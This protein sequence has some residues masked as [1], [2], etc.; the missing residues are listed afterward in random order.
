MS[1]IF[2]ANGSLYFRECTRN[3]ARL[4]SLIT[5]EGRRIQFRIAIG[6]QSAF[7]PYAV[8]Y[9]CLVCVYVWLSIPWVTLLG[10]QH[11]RHVDISNLLDILRIS[12][13]QDKAD[14]VHSQF[15]I[16][17]HRACML[18]YFLVRCNCT[19]IEFD[20]FCHRPSVEQLK[21]KLEWANRTIWMKELEFYFRNR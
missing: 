3:Q 13:S 12:D 8:C 17:K 19:L 15:N 7:G 9:G 14:I 20:C 11:R 4:V 5:L 6:H 1:C 2:L 21:R 10:F 16:L 18:W